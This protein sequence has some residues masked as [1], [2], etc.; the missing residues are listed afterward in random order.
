MERKKAE[1]VQPLFNRCPLKCS[2]E[3]ERTAIE[4]PEGFLRRCPECGQLLSACTAAGYQQSMQEFNAPE[5]TLPKGTSARRY[6]H[7]I[8]RILDA[9]ARRMG[10]E[11]EEL[12][13]LDVGC[14]S[15]A[16]LA[17]ASEM[18]FVVAGVEPA[19]RAADTARS[20]GFDVFTGLL[21]EAGYPDEDFDMV[22]M[23]EVIEHL[24]DPITVGCEIHRILK[25]GGILLIGTGN[26]DSWTVR[27]L[28]SKW[29][30]FDIGSHGG[31]I[32]FFTPASIRRFSGQCGFHL[33]E[34]RT[35]RVNLAER[36]DVSPLQYEL[37]KVCRE[38]L[39]L[40]ARW[41]GKGHD[42]LAI[43]EKK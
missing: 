42:M 4:L 35:K 31:H 8:G 26:A 12:R 30:Y 11:P 19:E 28:G 1:Q 37:L 34:I 16:L 41:F 18:G 7:R 6:R 5:G 14:S 38:F 29:E 36:R 17:M 3:L 40:P 13:L 2:R 33:A 21:E 15:G 43:L 10:K 20:M 22:T 39:A 24:T 23:F 32:S 9:A 27:F 25:P